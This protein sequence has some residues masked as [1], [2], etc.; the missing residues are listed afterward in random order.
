[1]R[2]LA[3][4]DHDDQLGS[5]LMISFWAWGDDEENTMLNLKRVFENLSRALRKL[6]K[7]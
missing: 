4:A 6:S 5:Q 3:F 7:A 1:V 2:Y